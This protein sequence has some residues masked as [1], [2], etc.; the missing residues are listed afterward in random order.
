MQKQPGHDAASGGLRF[1]PGL[2]A[3]LDALAAFTE[4]EGQLTRR[5]LS[6]AHIAAMRQVEAWMA[7][8]GMSVRTDPLLSVFGRYEG[9]EP[10]APAI[11]IGSH[12]DT[13]IDAGR[14]DG[15]LGVLAAIAVVAELR[16]RGRAARSCRRGGGVRR[17]GRLALL[18]AYPHVVGADR[19]GGA[20]AAGGPRRRRHHGARGAG[21]G[22]RQRRRLPR[23]RAP[24]GRDR[25]LPGAA[26]RAG[27]GSGGPGQ[28]AGGGDGHQRLGALGRDGHGL[29]RPRRH[30][31]DGAAARCAGR[32][33]RDDPGGGAHRRLRARSGGHGRPHHG[34]AGGAERDPRPG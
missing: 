32:G 1:G 13:V 5:Y 25:R 33:Q 17:G 28:G 2:M 11:M 22:R 24:Q 16:D 31:A 7:E 14:Y 20:R 21:P 23:L 10:G 12:I 18:G 8:A 3:R 27:A 15:N 9:K 34:A 4:V 19:S 29:R 6:P 30:G 26:Y